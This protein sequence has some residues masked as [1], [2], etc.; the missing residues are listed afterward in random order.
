MNATWT[1]ARAWARCGALLAFLLAGCAGEDGEDG[2]DGTSGTTPIVP[3]NTILQK[4]ED[5]PGVVLAITSITGATGPSGTFQ[6]GDRLAVR[7]TAKKNDGTSWALSELA[8]GHIL[9][10]GPTF[11]YQRVIPDTTDV[12]TAAVDNLDGTFTYTFAA[13]LPAAYLAP[14]NDTTAFGDLDGELTGD[15]LLAGTYT[16]GFWCRWNYTVD[17]ND[18]KDVGQA[19]AEFLVNGAATVASREVVKTDNCNRCHSEIQFHGGSRRT[20]PICLLCHTSGAEDSSGNGVAI[21]FRVMIHKLHDGEHLPSVLG[22]ATKSDGSRDYAVT[23]TPYVVSGSDYSEVAFPV[24][25]NL[26]TSMPRDFGYSGLS[27]TEKNLETEILRGATECT[28][29]HGDPDGTGP[30]TAPAQGDLYR[31]QPSRRACGSCHDDIDWALPYN[32]NQSSM[33]PQLDDSA[34]LFCHAPNA[35]SPLSTTKA[36]LHPINDPTVNPGVNFDITAISGGSLGGGNFTAGDKPSVTFTL[37]DDTGADVSLATLDSTSTILVGPTNNYQLVFPFATPNG[38]SSGLPVDFSGRLLSSSTTSKGSMSKVVDATAR[39]TLVVQFTSTTAF[40]VTGTTSG[41]LGGS[42]LA[43]ATSTNPSGSSLG[44]LLLT[45]AAVPQTIAVAF[46][47]PTAFTVTGSSS[48]AMGSGTMPAATSASTSFT[49][50]DGSVTFILS[51]GANAFAAG[52]TIHLVVF[53]CGAANPAL[54]G[55]VAG[56]ASFA[57]ND[58]FVYDTVGAAPTYTFAL[59]MDIATEFLGDGTGVVGQTLT[60]GNLPVYYGRQTLFERT[61]LAGVAT[62]LSAACAARD[63]FVVVAAIDAGLAAGDNV[64]LDNGVVG[65]EEYVLVGKVDAATSRIWFRTPLRYSHAA[66]SS[67]QEATFQQRLEG[68][69]Y[70]LTAAT[71]TVTSLAPGFV[72]GNA[73]VLSYRTDGRFGWNRAA[74]DTLQAVFVP[75]INDSPDLDASWG[76]WSGLSFVDG[77]YS[78][79]IWGRK[80]AVLK[81]QN[82]VQ[83]YN[84]IGEAST[85]NILYGAATVIEPYH[86]ISAGTNCDACHSMVGPFH[87]GNR[88]DFNTCVLCHGVAGSEDWP[89][90]GTTPATQ[91]TT[92]VSINFRT[93][94]HKIHRGE[95]LYNASTYV[96]LGNSSSVNAYG[97]IRF[98]AMPDGTRECTKCH[99]TADN[100]FDP[101]VRQH[102]SQSPPTR[103]WRAACGA[104]HDS[105]AAQ[106]HIDI[107][108]SA[109]G[110][111]S[112]EICHGPGSDF[113]VEIMHKVR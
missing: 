38:A 59:P 66:A 87:G 21:D 10:S 69:H 98:P 37:K 93:M 20:V 106:A 96:V 74:G 44:T 110:L 101:G 105:P 50:T 41:A 13:T 112:C 49:S 11:N 91:P 24:W 109:S 77:T 15:P 99:G 108:T 92:G 113:S 83:T 46:T 2:K 64:V 102:P 1:N 14:I 12:L 70:T 32:S 54:F 61:G 78:A 100:W 80:N 40:T 28:K 111:E 36:H 90:Y 29:C 65:K 85:E 107:N 67:F 89:I 62:T 79:S 23:P 63:R 9:V 25:P 30:M 68:I 56:T 81:I 72:A 57:V 75:P 88:R 27:S 33:P 16:V 42:A 39:E 71:G 76:D 45:S 3:T 73:I 8:S 104:C 47:S 35:P 26:N 17:G 60:A 19:T 94:L 58:R 4:W 6:A 18:Y 51:S 7:F 5:P 43:S 31:S 95:E 48:G 52:N 103:E 34:C 22:V 82:E 86:V 97:E 55:I 84:G 53:R